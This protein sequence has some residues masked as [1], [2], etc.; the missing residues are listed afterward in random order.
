MS[1]NLQLA[2]V[3][4]AVVSQLMTRENPATGAAHSPPESQPTHP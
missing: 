1:S 2:K 3:I 4:A